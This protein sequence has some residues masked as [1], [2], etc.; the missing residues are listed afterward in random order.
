VRSLRILD[1]L[2]PLDAQANE[3]LGHADVRHLAERI[4]TIRAA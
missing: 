1:R 2:A 4:A 3:H